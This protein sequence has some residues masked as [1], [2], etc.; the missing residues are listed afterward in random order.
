MADSVV[1]IVNTT[2]TSTE[3]P[4]SNTSYNLITTDANTSYVIKDVQ[5]STV[6]GDLQASINNYPV[7]NWNQSLTGSEVVDVSSTLSVTSSSFPAIV[8]IV[9]GRT[10][11]NSTTD[12]GLVYENRFLYAEQSLSSKVNNI[13]SSYGGYT[14]QETGAANSYAHTFVEAGGGVIYQLYENVHG[15]AS[16][17]RWDNA[18]SYDKYYT[19]GS[20]NVGCWDGATKEIYYTS[21]VGGSYNLYKIDYTSSSTQSLVYSGFDKG[22]TP[23]SYARGTSCRNYLF[24]VTSGS[25]GGGNTILCY[26]KTTNLVHKFT[27]LYDVQSIYGISFG[28]YWALAV[29]YDAAS[30]Q[31][32]I[33][34]K[35]DSSSYTYIWK[36]VLPVTKSTM[37]A[38]ASDQTISTSTVQRGF[39]NYG[40][41]SLSDFRY[42]G[43]TGNAIVGDESSG[44]TM[45]FVSYSNNTKFNKV[46]YSAASYTAFYS[47]STAFT[48]FPR[49][50]TYI[51]SGIDSDFGFLDGFKIRITG[52]KTT[53]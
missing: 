36:D 23:S 7:G 47:P 53:S 11:S 50:N 37:D 34:R 20:Y 43:G 48:F 2:L 31:F 4:D 15:L 10:Q 24:Y 51:T 26:N 49:L 42:N 21:T 9:E 19:N 17:L 32:V 30:D 44:N 35:Q 52:V 8:N 45:Y 12:I 1:E 25:M 38:Y 33:Y 6:L 13:N 22:Y 14:G 39:I 46:D 18:G 28:G 29:S 40:S 41:W 5:V 27:G 3:L 16:L